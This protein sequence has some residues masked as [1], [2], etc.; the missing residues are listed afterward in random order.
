MHLKELQTQVDTWISSTD[1]GYFAPLTNLGVLMEEVGEMSRIMVRTY[2]EQR[3][4]ESDLNKSLADEIADVLWVIAALANQCDIDL[5]SAMQ[6][7]FEKK[8]SRDKG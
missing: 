8:N 5:E 4:K 7:N 1:K 6:K 3:S 2:G